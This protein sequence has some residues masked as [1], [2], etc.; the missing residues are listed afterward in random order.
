MLQKKNWILVGACVSA[1]I[2]VGVLIFSLLTNKQTNFIEPVSSV[3]TALNKY[4]VMNAAARQAV[5]NDGSPAVYYW[6]PG[7]HDEQDK[8]IIWLRGGGGCNNSSDCQTR[9]VQNQSETSSN[10]APDSQRPD[11][12]LSDDPT[13]NPDFYA[14]NHVMI[15][16]CSS[17]TWTGDATQTE[18]DWEIQFKGNRIVQS[19]IEDLHLEQAQAVILAGSSGG[20]TGAMHLL[21]RVAA[22]L[23]QVR[24][25]GLIDSSW[26]I[27]FPS[28]QTSLDRHE[29]SQQSYT[30]RQNLLDESCVNANPANPAVCFTHDIAEPYIDNQVYYFINQQDKEKLA[31]LGVSKPYS[32][33]E[34]QYVNEHAVALRESLVDV[35]NVLAPMGSQH[36]LLIEKFFYAPVA[37]N[38]SLADIFGNWYFNRGGLTRY[39]QEER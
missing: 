1:V 19:V 3:Q 10:L 22:Q 12:I 21:D 39:V 29:H 7:Q 5:C 16:Y 15:H 9:M 32:D 23:P 20:G 34:K 31:A 26:E 37:T 28:F 4:T 25:T 36:T 33:Q 11:G 27:N 2:A 8:W 30:Y 17:D 6:R 35:E 18:A 38:L 13:V 24:V 14:W